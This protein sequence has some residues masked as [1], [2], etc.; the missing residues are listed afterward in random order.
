MWFCCVY[1]SSSPRNINLQILLVLL[2]ILDESCNK[3]T[4]KINLG[5]TILLWFLFLYVASQCGM[6][7]KEFTKVSV[8][9]YA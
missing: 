9:E 5:V 7:R 2:Y 6:Y 1:K 4:V 3:S 8:L